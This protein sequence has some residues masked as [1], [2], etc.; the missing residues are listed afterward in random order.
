MPDLKLTTVTARKCFIMS[1]MT[2][3]D[4]WTKIDQY[5]KMVFVEFLEMLCRMA[6][7]HFDETP[8]R[9]LTL[10]QRLECVLENVL[11]LKSLERK[12]VVQE[13]FVDSDADISDDDY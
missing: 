4:E 9:E 6:L 1:K 8:V 7:Y 5:N 13:V 11:L 3:V 12:P 2:T 10:T